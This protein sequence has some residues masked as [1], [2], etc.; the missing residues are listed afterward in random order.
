MI[1]DVLIKNFKCFKSLIVP[2]LGRIT[3][4]G[5][6]NNV[7]KTAFLEAL[8]LFLDIRNPVVTINQYGRRGIEQVTLTTEAMWEPIFRNYDMDIEILISYLI[9]IIKIY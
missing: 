4:V 2:E 9:S 6:R 3:L 8:F 7:G 5:G 1:T